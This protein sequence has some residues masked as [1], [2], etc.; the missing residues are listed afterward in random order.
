MLRRITL[1]M[2][3]GMASGFA[4]QAADM[5]AVQQACKM[6]VETYCATVER[7]EGR[8]L[9]CLK[10][11]RDNVSEGCKTAVRGMQEQRQSVAKAPATTT[12]TTWSE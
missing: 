7:G 12:T 9:N 5:T 3:V 4:A 8:I 10:E 2:I 1:G 11:H 6:D